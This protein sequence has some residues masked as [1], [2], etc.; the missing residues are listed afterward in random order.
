MSD[1]HHS[2]RTAP[3]QV[4]G[5]S[6]DTRRGT[7]ALRYPVQGQSMIIRMP[8]WSDGGCEVV[9]GD[10]EFMAVG[11]VGGD[12]VVAA[13]QVLDEGVTGGDGPH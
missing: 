7:V 4:Y 6:W 2:S 11:D 5:I 13:A 8:C 10:A 12:V 9:E 1:E 3:R